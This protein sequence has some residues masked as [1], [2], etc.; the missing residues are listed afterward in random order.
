MKQYKLCC[1]SPAKDLS[2]QTSSAILSESDLLFLLSFLLFYVLCCSMVQ[3]LN[4]KYAH[5][6]IPL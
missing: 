5:P 3:H 2:I 4:L 6:V 1:R